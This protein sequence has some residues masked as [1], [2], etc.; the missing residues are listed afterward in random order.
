MK[1]IKLNHIALLAALSFTSCQ[2]I[3]EKE[4][5]GILD[6]GSFFQTADDAL[7]ATNAANEP[8]FFSSGKNNF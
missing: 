1:N 7:Q 2:G 4:P 3:L 5:L 8:L 6:A